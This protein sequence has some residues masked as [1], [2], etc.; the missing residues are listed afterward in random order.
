MNNDFFSIKIFNKLKRF[1]YWCKC[2]GWHT[3]RIRK[4]VIWGS[5]HPIRIVNGLKTPSG[6]YTLPNSD[7]HSHVIHEL[8][9]E[10]RE[11]G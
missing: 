7:S 4:F 3:H 11:L 1:K 9:G 6:V 10:Y 5:V 2:L 8:A